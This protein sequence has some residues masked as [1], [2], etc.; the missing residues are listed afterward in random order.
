MTDYIVDNKLFY[1]LMYNF[2]RLVSFI[3]YFSTFLYLFGFL[4]S[5]YF[6]LMNFYVKITISIFLIYRFNSLRKRR[7][8][9]TD[10]DRKI[11]FSAGIYILALSFQE[12]VV[13]FSK[14]I[15]Q[16]M[17]KNNFLLGFTDDIKIW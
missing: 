7:L 11:C 6:L 4:N 3:V 8:V 15:R 1:V 10:L 14:E 17:L 9:F 16:F 2:L 12:Y 13:Y 5:L